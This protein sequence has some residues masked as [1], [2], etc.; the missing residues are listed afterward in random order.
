MFLCRYF[1]ICYSH[2][3]RGTEHKSGDEDL[4]VRFSGF[5]GKS[6][7]PTRGKLIKMEEAAITIVEDAASPPAKT[8]QPSL[9]TNIT[10]LQHLQ[11]LPHQQQQPVTRTLQRQQQQQSPKCDSQTRFQQ[12]PVSPQRSNQQPPKEHQV[13]RV[14]SFTEGSTDAVDRF[15]RVSS[16]GSCTE[17]KDVQPEHSPAQHPAPQAAV[18]N[19]RAVNESVGV[20]EQPIEHVHLSSHVS[21]RD[22]TTVQRSTT[23]PSTF[24]QIRSSINHV[25]ASLSSGR[26]TSRFGHPDDLCNN[27]PPKTKNCTGG[28]GV[29]KLYLLLISKIFPS[30]SNFDQL[31]QV[32]LNV[33][34]D[35]GSLSGSISSIPIKLNQRQ[36]S[37]NNSPAVP[38]QHPQQF[39]AVHQRALSHININHCRMVRPTH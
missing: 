39:R 14:A 29:N 30:R 12:Q 7:L 17:L 4:H 33:G 19:A 25:S 5:A 21:P 38:E 3:H 2:G 10:V 8:V 16:Q 9:P 11:Q 27:K 37:A 34:Q 18:I 13:A 28:G 15:A 20:M 26:R 6:S 1:G 32:W 35:S 24:R 22:V 36:S 31:A 23:N